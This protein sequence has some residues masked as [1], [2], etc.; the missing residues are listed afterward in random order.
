MCRILYSKRLSTQAKQENIMGW[1]ISIYPQS[2]DELIARRTKNED[3][4]DYSRACLAHSLK[5]E[6]L[7]TAWEFIDKKTEA[8]PV[9]YIGYDR[10]VF[11]KDGTSGYKDG[12]ESNHPDHYTCPPSYLDMVPPACPEWRKKVMDYNGRKKLPIKVG[13]VYGLADC[14]ISAVR[15][16]S[17][18]GKE[19]IGEDSTGKKWKVKRSQLSG[20]MSIGWLGQEAA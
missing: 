8:P 13:L 19:L 20:E 1:L 7:W 3:N 17:V 10:L 4:A 5:G 2:K 9:L 16:V 12:C 6:V 18:A 14:A 11:N 15:I